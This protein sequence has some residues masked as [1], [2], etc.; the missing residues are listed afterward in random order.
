MTVLGWLIALLVNL[1]LAGLMAAVVRQLLGAQVGWP[2]SILVSYVALVAFIPVTVWVAREVGFLDG[3]DQLKIPVLLLIGLLVLAFA[4]A[5]VL[6]TA[7]VV[8]LEALLPTGSIP[9]VLSWPALIA[10]AWRRMVRY[11][12]LAWIVTRSGFSGALQQGPRSERFDAAL[13]RTLDEAGPSFVKLGQLLSTRPD[14]I[15]PSTATALS[16]LQSSALPVPTSEIVTVLERAWGRD[17][18]QVLGRLDP[19]PL[20]AASIAQVHAARTTDGRDVV[21]KV[22][23]PTAA[24]L[25]TVD[26]DIML[27]F[28]RTANRRFEWASEIGF[29]ELTVGLV[30][31]MNE[32]LDY[33]I[34]AF[35]T[36]VGRRLTANVPELVVP[37]VDQELSTDEV[38]VMD[39]IE[40]V[41]VPQA[42]DDMT[43]ERREE[44]AHALLEWVI[45]GVLVEGFFHADL[46]PGNILVTPEHKLGIL[47]FGA[48]GLI[49][50]ETRKLLA[51]LIGAILEDDAVVA[52]TALQMI[53]DLPADVDSRALKRDLG[54]LLARVHA[55][56]ETDSTLFSD[57]V[58]LL[59]GHRIGVPG[60]IAGAFRTLGAVEDTLKVLVPENSLVEGARSAMPGV[61]TVLASP[62]RAVKRAAVEALVVGSV[63]KRIP[64]RVER[65]T[66]ALAAG[67]F[68]V[69]TRPLADVG[70]RRWLRRMLDDALSVIFAAVLAVV[71]VN[72]ATSHG[73]A[74]LTEQL[75]LAQ[76]GA[77]VLGLIAMVLALRVLVRVFSRRA[78]VDTD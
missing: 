49:D 27:R 29:E 2:R 39:L 1:A 45:R 55:S 62:T 77:A 9:S 28:A 65:I 43:P 64:D 76:L 10:K 61:L 42:V 21:V 3:G 60:D 17:P 53:F 13:V 7:V 24:H 66:D 57:L 22:R 30:K 59:R 71:A 33:G 18:H 72:L 63:A 35:N 32:E 14:V 73:G 67:E 78:A 41:P 8:I 5:L 23:R 56:G 48:V 15:P 40:G 20:G 36:K 26:S 69:N 68:N 6:C 37:E 11:R 52:T 25:V 19:T 74:M 31:V 47:D 4:W 58:Q 75:S 70:E 46:H 44:L 38:L 34:E 12:K 54:R 51:A 50:Q 16:K